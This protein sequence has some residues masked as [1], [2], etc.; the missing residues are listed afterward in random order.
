MVGNGHATSLI[1]S[2]RPRL[3]LS[4]REFSL[5]SALVFLNHSAD[6]RL[7][8]HVLYQLGPR[9][10]HS[11]Q[12]R[13][14]DSDGFHES[15]GIHVP[16]LGAT[17]CMAANQAAALYLWIRT[18]HHP[19]RRSDWNRLDY[20]VHADA[21]QEGQSCAVKQTAGLNLVL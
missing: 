6:Q 8:F 19:E 12:R 17:A 14:R 9:G 5:L 3:D 13:A 20:H 10:L 1:Q 4:C 18:C 7:I 2:V 11:R 21:G 15:D 16:N